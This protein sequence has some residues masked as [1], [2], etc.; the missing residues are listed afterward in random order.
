MKLAIKGGWVVTQNPNREIVRSDI[1]IENGRIA[2][3]GPVDSADEVIDASGCAVIP[4][5]INSHTHISM[6]LMRGMADNLNLE[7]FLEKTYKIDGKRT[8]EDVR[9]GAEL[10][11]IE[12]LRA[13]NTTFLDMYY[14]ED[15]VAKAV[16]QSGIRGFLGWVVLD[17]E[18]TM[19]GGNPLSNCE[20]FISTHTQL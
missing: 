10:G 17:E 16:Q 12:M 7:Q 1:L 6:T 9:V 5:L 4:G 8:G 13:G 2:S 19:Q 15:E 14:F 11:A 20:E 3:I 18:F